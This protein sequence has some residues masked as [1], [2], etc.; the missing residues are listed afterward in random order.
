[1]RKIAFLPLLITP[2]LI[3]GSAAAAPSLHR[4]VA[5]T[6]LTIDQTCAAH[7]TITPDGAAGRITLDAIA[8]HPEELDQIS[9]AP[10]GAN[11]RLS[12]RMHNCWGSGIAFFGNSRSL[13]MTLHVAPG[14]ALDIADSG[15]VDYSLGAIDGPLHLDVSGGITLAEAS[16][17]A[18]QIDASGGVRLHFD[19]LKGALRA[20]LSG[21]ADLRIG[22]IEAPSVTLDASG[23]VQ[24]DIGGGSITTLK[25]S[26]SGG[27]DMRIDATVQDADADAS[28]GG[29][30]ALARVTGRLDKESSIGGDITV[31]R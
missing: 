11:A 7:V 21:G 8:E 31:G 6:G 4:E 9:F 30:I 27:V 1:M 10:E 20:D 15:G 14:T 25:A 3:A 19:S 2:I 28:G 16:T 24:T 18:A 13:Q 23:G 5:G 12:A 29:S 26:A 17:A 22:H